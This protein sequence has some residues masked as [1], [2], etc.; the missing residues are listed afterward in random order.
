M[1]KLTLSHVS[2]AGNFVWGKKWS[3]ISLS[4]LLFQGRGL[5][6]VKA[7]DDWDSMRVYCWLTVS[8]HEMADAQWEIVVDLHIRWQ[9]LCE[10]LLNCA[11]GIR[12]Q[13]VWEIIELR[14]WQQRPWERLIDA[15]GIRWQR[16][17]ER[18]SNY[19]D[20]IRW[21]RLCERLWIY[22]AG[23]KWQGLCKRLL[24]YS[25]SI[26]W[27]RLW[28]N[29]VLSWHYMTETLWQIID[30]PCRS[31]ERDR[32]LTQLASDDRDC[33][34][35]WTYPVGIRLQRQCEKTSYTARMTDRSAMRDN[36]RVTHGLLNIRWQKLEN[37]N[38]TKKNQKTYQVV[39]LCEL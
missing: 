23:I 10:R 28:D 20:G 6:K 37:N 35:L 27:R 17:C 15:D 26:R 24:I 16:L 4:L 3:S 39:S 7:S 36:V 29:N 32:R 2:A 18:L 9:W 11:V 33:E 19:A 13:A 14:S 1:L 38:K 25:A 22:Q 5:T 34:R 12:W 30:I 8:W 31:S 21:Q